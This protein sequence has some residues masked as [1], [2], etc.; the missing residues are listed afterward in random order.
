MTTTA[1][2]TGDGVDLCPAQRRALDVLLGGLGVWNVAAV[3]ADTGAGRTTVLRAAHAAVGGTFLGITDFLDALA[4]RH[5]QAIEETFQRLVWDA[6]QKSPAVFVDDLNL[7]VAVAGG[8]CHFY[9]RSGMLDA[10]LTALAAYALGAGRKLVFG[11]EGRPPGPVDERACYANIEEFTA[12]DYRALCQTFWGR[13]PKT[14][15][16][17]SAVDYDK[18]HRFAPKLNAHQ[19]R[20]A[21]AFV[22]PAGRTDT[23]ETQTD[24]DRLIDF[25]RSQRMASNVDLEEVQA[26][27]LADLKGVD[28]VVQALEANVILPLEND[29]LAAELDLR[30][31]RGVLL[32]GPPGTGKTTVGRALARRLRGKFF[33]IDGTFISGTNSFYAMVGD[34]FRAAKQNAPAVIFIDDSDVIFENGEEAGL[35]RY[36]LTM[37]DGLESA[38]SGRVCVMMTAMNV[39]SLPPALI[40][41]GRI[42]LWLETRLPDAGGR[43]AILRAN[44]ARLPAAL[45]GGVDVAR[46]AAEADGFTGA[47]LKRL[48]EDGKIAYAYDRARG[49]SPR[50]ATDYFLDAIQAVRANKERYAQAEAAARAHRPARP[51]WFDATSSTMAM[52][53]DDDRPRS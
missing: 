34:V 22:T 33:L 53:D 46:L 27:D 29:A 47:D 15:A 14:A 20:G 7:L 6:L 51:P 36:L 4:G 43:A 45:A 18:V 49:L 30:P 39:A 26:V 40:R 52:I 31:K 24:T 50:P 42:E 23:Q 37:L 16:A 12:A 11:C 19:L 2:M 8:G 38:S 9:P 13:D 5:P 3:S 28:D 41:S 44:L 10:A 17:A 21:C 25:L 1:I 32:A 48:A 35:Y